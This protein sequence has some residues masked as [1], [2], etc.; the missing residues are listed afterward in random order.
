MKRTLIEIQDGQKQS[1]FEMDRDGQRW[2]KKDN[3]GK[4]GQR[5]TI[6]AN[7]DKDEQKW[8]KMNKNGQR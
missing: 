5:R 4:H 3:N 8:T 1:D 7:M 2:T 6:M